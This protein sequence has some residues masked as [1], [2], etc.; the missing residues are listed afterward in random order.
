MKNNDLLGWSFVAAIF[1]LSFIENKNS[2]GATVLSKNYNGK[3]YQTGNRGFSVKSVF[4]KIEKFAKE[5]GVVNSWDRS[6]RG[7]SYYLDFDFEGVNYELRISNHTKRGEILD[8][9]YP[10]IKTGMYYDKTTYKRCEYQILDSETKKRFF[11]LVGI[12]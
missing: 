11:D 7:N 12:K 5:K 1:G 6:V 8:Y 10:E 4:D 3:V 2:I 9:E